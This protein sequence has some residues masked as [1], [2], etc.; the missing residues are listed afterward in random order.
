MLGWTPRTPFAEGLL[1]ATIEW[2]FA[3]KDRGEVASLLARGGLM[4][5]PVDLD[6]AA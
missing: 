5:P 3:T 1:R 2:Y 4:R 6:R